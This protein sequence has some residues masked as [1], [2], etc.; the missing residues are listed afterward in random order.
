MSLR[1]VSCLLLV[2]G[3]TPVVAGVAPVGEELA[4]KDG[5]PNNEHTPAVAFGADG[6]GLVVWTDSRD[7]LRGRFVEADGTLAAADLLLVA[8]D[9]LVE[10]PGA[11]R[12]TYRRDPVLIA[13][14]GRTFWLFWTEEL[15]DVVI[16]FFREDRTIL[17]RDVRGQ[18]FD[19]AGQPLGESFRVNANAR[20]FQSLPQVLRLDCGA[21]CAED[22]FVVAW[23]SD[24]RAA[25]NGPG[26]GIFAQL[27]R[28]DGVPLGAQPRLSA[29]GPATGVA[30]A[31]GPLG[32][33]L[34][35]WEEP[36]AKS[37]R[38]VLRGRF[39]DASLRAA[40]K[41]FLVSPGTPGVQR[42]AS[43]VWNP[44][45][46]EATV[47][48]DRTMPATGNYRVVAQRIAYPDVVRGAA[49]VLTNGG[50]EGPAA[51]AVTASNSVLALWISWQHAYPYF[52][53]GAE[54]DGKT[55]SRGAEFRV[56]QWPRYDLAVAKGPNGRMLAVWEGWAYGLRHGIVGR[57]LAQAR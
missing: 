3:A 43:P 30:L 29:P 52:L 56:A 18:R 21:A 53:Q 25:R 37:V 36:V 40:T 41:P 12:E 4:I 35:V 32:G 44:A 39:L 1:T 10:V 28:F 46:G 49:I 8:N 7:G 9:R 2:L 38:T 51:A 15:Q 45:S 33:A 13:G 14:A 48:F 20:G 42:R 11:G 17:D 55:A 5:R 27:Y 47:L 24:D 31:G 22:P 57:W 26:D 6:R 23:E 50:A 16:D 54:L 19:A 34:A